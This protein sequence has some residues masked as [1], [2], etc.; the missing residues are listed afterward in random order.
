M[1]QHLEQAMTAV[2]EAGLDAERGSMQSAE[3]A[4]IVAKLTARNG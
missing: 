3:H 1:N 2:M 4:A